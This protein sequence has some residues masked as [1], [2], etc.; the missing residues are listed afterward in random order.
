MATL[1]V[2]SGLASELDSR[3]FRASI[4]TAASPWAGQAREGREPRVVSAATTLHAPLAEAAGR[5]LLAEVAF[6]IDGDRDEAVR[7]LETAPAVSGGLAH[8]LVL[9]ARSRH[10]NEAAARAL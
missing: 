4:P 9:R 10:G 2:G 1:A 8:V 7:L 3:T 6:V 5:A